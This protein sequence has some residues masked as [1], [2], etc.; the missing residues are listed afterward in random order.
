MKM[1]DSLKHGVVAAAA[2]G[3]MSAPA[4]G[5]S[6][7]LSGTIEVA[8]SSTVLPMATFVAEQFRKQYPN[9]TVPIASIGTGGGFRQ[10]T[11]GQSD[12]SNASRPIKA[13]EYKAAKAAG[14]EFVETPVAYD[15]LT[16]AVNPENTWATQMTTEQ[17]ATL[18]KAG[19][20]VKSWKDLDASYPDVPV[21]IFMPATTSGTFDYFKEVVIGD[22]GNMREDAAVSENDNI[23]VNGIAG[24]KG[25]IGFF[26]SAYYFENRDK[27]T[28]VGIQNSNGD[29]VRPTAE[30][31]ES[32]E[33]NPF[34]RPLFVYW[35]IDS[36]DRPEVAAYAE[37][38]LD[39]APTAAEEVGYV[40]LPEWCAEASMDRL[41]NR[42]AGSVYYT[43]ELEAKEGTLKELMGVTEEE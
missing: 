43:D 41:A 19:S 1:F 9:V 24:N 29:F 32:G 15:G 11:A 3:L 10:F 30:T 28:S 33:Y 12:A 39:V 34:S 6:D 35:K 42:T 37:F 40:R 31:I 25:G 26:G 21:K 2:A 27:L 14:I 16:I 5:Q 20:K 17:L 13:K 38:F 4:M 7:N 36:L 22:E 8:G 23:L 18:F